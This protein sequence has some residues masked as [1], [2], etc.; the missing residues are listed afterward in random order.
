ME[1]QVHNMLKKGVIEESSSPWSSP[2]ILVPKKSLDETPKYRFCVDFRALNAVTQFDTYSLP[3]FEETVSTLH[4]SKYFS[5]IDCYS[6]FWQIK[7]AEED[8]M[9]TAFSKPPGRYHFHRLPYVL[10]NSPASF[11]RLMDVVLRDLTGTECW[12]FLDNLIVF[13]DTIEEHASRLEHVLQRFEKANLQLEPA[14]CVFAQ[15]QVQYLGYVVSRDGIIAS[16]DKVKA[17]RQYPIPKNVRLQIL[18]RISVV[19]QTF[20]P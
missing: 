4:W 1:D 20:N 18:F 9:K 17:V 3:L 14:K 11:Q 8:K 12:I 16:P 10:S 13:A 2:V 7:I 15:P 6:G 19:L 5:V